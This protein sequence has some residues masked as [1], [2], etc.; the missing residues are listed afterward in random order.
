MYIVHLFIHAISNYDSLF[1]DS[2]CIIIN[3]VCLR[4]LVFLRSFPVFIKEMRNPHNLDKIID[5]H[6]AVHA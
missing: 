5:D 3:L 6:D 2:T 4:H 1:S